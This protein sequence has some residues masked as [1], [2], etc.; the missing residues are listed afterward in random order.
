MLVYFLF[1]ILVSVSTIQIW[2]LRSSSGVH[3]HF[4][5]T[6]KQT[7]ELKQSKELTYIIMNLDQGQK[8]KRNLQKNK[9]KL[10]MKSKQRNDKGR[11]KHKEKN[12]IGMPDN[13][14]DP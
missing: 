10:E 9:N 5:K 1:S 14:T 13:Q 11:M 4:T 7:Q 3:S 8:Y 2:L 12:V 6:W